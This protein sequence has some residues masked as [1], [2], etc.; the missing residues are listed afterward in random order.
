MSQMLARLKEN[1]VLT[2]VNMVEVIGEIGM[3]I[4]LRIKTTGLQIMI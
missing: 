4:V 3:W 1:K 2:L